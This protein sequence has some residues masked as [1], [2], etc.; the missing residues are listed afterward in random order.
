MASLAPK[1]SVPPETLAATVARIAPEELVRVK[2]A[3]VRFGVVPESTRELTVLAAVCV[4][5][6]AR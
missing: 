4:A 3:W 2:P 1:A 5:A 6:A